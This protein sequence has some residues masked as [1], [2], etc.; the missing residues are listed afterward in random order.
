MVF[1][2]AVLLSIGILLLV[3]GS[4][5]F[6]ASAVRIAKELGVSEFV[7][8]LTLVAVGTSVPEVGASIAA[9]IKHQSG[10]VIGNVLGSNIANINLIMGIIA[11]LWVLKTDRQMLERDGYIMLSAAILFYLSM[12]NEV[13]SRIEGLVFLLLYGAY[14]LFIVETRSKRDRVYNFKDFVIYFFQFRY[15]RTTSKT[16]FESNHVRKKDKVHGLFLTRP[17]VKDLGIVVVSTGAIWYGANLLVEAAVFFANL[18]HLP[19]T[20]IGMSLIAI[21]TSLPELGVTLA[22]AKK[23]LGN[24]VVGNIIG[25]NI[26][27]I[28]LIIGVTSTIS[29][30]AITKATILTAAPFMIAMTVLFLVFIRSRWQ[31]ER[32]EAILFLFLYGVFLGYIFFSSRG[33]L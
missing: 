10:I 19:K 29:P 28:F 24:I 32:I 21:G 12:L 7:I 11:V 3:K 9:S 1:T 33:T 5:F 8:G 13:I 4:D 17:L 26:V 31:L 15:L 23:G 14:V 2:E 6:V 16:F 18:L 20:V 22:A 27:N 30:L 25:S